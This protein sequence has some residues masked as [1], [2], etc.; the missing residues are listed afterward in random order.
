MHDDV[1]A[2]IGTPLGASAHGAA[3]KG[4]NPKVR[5]LKN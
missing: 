2:V 3:G 4:A 1:A 5:R